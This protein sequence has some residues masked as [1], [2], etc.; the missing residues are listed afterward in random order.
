MLNET[1]SGRDLGRKKKKK[2]THRRHF[3]V[4]RTERKF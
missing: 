1:K 4:G 2:K 3:F